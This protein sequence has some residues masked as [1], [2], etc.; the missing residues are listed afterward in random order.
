MNLAVAATMA[1]LAAM[2]TVELRDFELIRDKFFDPA[3]VSEVQAQ[4]KF[5]T[6]QGG[7]A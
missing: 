1:D 7:H 3:L 6:M 4:L 5:A 2:M